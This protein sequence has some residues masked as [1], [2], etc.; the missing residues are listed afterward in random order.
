MNTNSRT[1]LGVDCGFSYGNQGFT[2]HNVSK[3]CCATNAIA[4][5]QSYVSTQLGCHQSSFVT[6]WAA[7]NNY[8]IV[9]DLFSRN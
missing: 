5:N 3:Y 4:L 1:A 6:A 7:T 8:N 9:T 2:W